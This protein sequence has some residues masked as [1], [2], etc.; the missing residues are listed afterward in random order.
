[1]T[2]EEQYQANNE[3]IIF[4][5]KGYE[6][7]WRLTKILSFKMLL[8]NRDELTKY[9]SV[10]YG[11]KFI[12]DNNYID[13]SVTNGLVYSALVELA[14]HIE[15]LLTLV[16]FIRRTSDF[17]KKVTW[18]RA[19]DLT[20]KFLPNIKQ[21]IKNDHEKLLSRFLIPNRSYVER[22]VQQ[23]Y[24]PGIESPNL[25][26]YDFGVSNLIAYMDSA[27][28]VYEKIKSFYEQYKHG[29]KIRLKD[30]QSSSSRKDFHRESL[31][32]DVL[33]LHNDTW[34]DGLQNGRIQAGVMFPTHGPTVT[35]HFGEL[36][37][38]KNLFQY[39]QLFSLPIDYIVEIAQKVMNLIFCLRDNRI[40]YIHPRKPGYNVIF[41]PFPRENFILYDL[42]LRSANGELLNLN[43]FEEIFKK[44]GKV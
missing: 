21:E 17:A 2:P 42:Y 13:Y 23:T 28:D 44:K 4:F 41:M 38:D 10:S 12:F 30:V 19:N 6:I 14:M 25:E 37:A 3:Q 24:S 8:E 9:L 39:D 20:G 35:K 36:I 15:D 7:T 18:Y 43:S 33:S 11:E 16:K 1:M 27:I 5:F 26:F 40:D 31:A 29:L 34:E 32:G 22:C